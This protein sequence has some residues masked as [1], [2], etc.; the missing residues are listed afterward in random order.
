LSSAQ[1]PETLFDQGNNL[2]NS[3][4]YEEAIKDYEQILELD[5]HSPELYFNLANAYYKIGK[6]AESIF[7]F[8]KAKLLDPENKDIDIN[9]QFAQNMSMDS[10]E[11]LPVSLGDRVINSITSLYSVSAWAKILIGLSVILSLLFSLYLLNSNTV[12]KRIYFTFF[13][14]LMGVFIFLFTLTYSRNEEKINQRFAIVFDTQVNILGEPNDRSEVLFILHEG[15][16]TV[17]LDSL[18]SF[19]KIKIANG[20]EGW[21][22]TSSLKTLN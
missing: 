17:V 15:T 4:S 8:E 21:I 6:V 9:L 11:M 7:Y 14:L 2:Y 20:S 22:E 12:Y 16:K 13:W 5:I 18:G 3:G 1:T 10:I 19:Y